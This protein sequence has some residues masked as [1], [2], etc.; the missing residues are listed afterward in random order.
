[1]RPYETDPAAIYAQSFATVRA[2]ARL[3]R[4]LSW[5]GRIVQPASPCTDLELMARLLAGLRNLAAPAGEPR[6]TGEDP[7]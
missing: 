7:T 3:D 6:I 2:E 1:M 4:T 5:S